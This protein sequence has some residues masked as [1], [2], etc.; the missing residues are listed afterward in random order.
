MINIAVGEY[1]DQCVI[2][3]N[4]MARQSRAW[5][6]V[7]SAMA[8]LWIATSA[9]AGADPKAPVQSV[10]DTAAAVQAQAAAD[11]A[12]DANDYHIGSMDLLE[13]KVL[14]VADMSRSVRVDSRGN[15][16]LPLV[17]VVH[18]GGLTSYELEQLITARL[19]VDLI[20]DPQVSVFIK[21]FTSQR[22]TVQG[23][24]KRA[25]VYDF[26]G[27]ATL[28]QAISIGGG[29]DEKANEMAI[30]VVRR[31]PSGMAETMSFDLSAIRQNQIAD[32][33]LKGG[34]V[35]VVVE[36]VPIT[37][38]GQVSKTGVFYPRGRATLMQ[39]I[40]QAGGLT[41][42]ADPSI[43]V[44]SVA[45]NG[46]KV[47]LAYDL[48]QIR[49]GK[50]PDPEVHPGDMV[51]V[52]KSTGRSILNAITSTLRGFVSFGTVPLAR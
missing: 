27:R 34:D 46:Q 10:G 28:L 39:V 7:V 37:V 44:F 47:G 20:Q 1:S 41:E 16:S 11:Y 43:K 17:G 33:I 30:K 45:A 8:M 6:M 14:Q 13:I 48:D 25:G 15:I 38:E 40:S 19:A 49:E 42:M 52:E 23:L 18:A 24:V 22:I 31:Q 4:E 21:E 50:L 32:P 35:V 12:A 9:F 51:V 5:V 26:Q 3:G 36:S 2:A 29:L